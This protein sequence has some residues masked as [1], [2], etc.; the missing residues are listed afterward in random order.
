MAWRAHLDAVLVR[1]A[2]EAD[3]L[4]ETDANLAA[5]EGFGPFGDPAR[6][7]A[8]LALGFLD[9][10]APS[11]PAGTLDLAVIVVRDTLAAKSLACAD[12]PA[13]PAATVRW[14]FWNGSRWQALDLLKDETLAFTRSGHIHVKMP[15]KGITAKIRLES[16]LTMPQRHWIRARLD[17]S[18][19]ERAPKIRAIRINTVP[20]EQAETIRDE[21][22]GGSDGSRFQRFALGSR[23]VLARF[24]QAR[25]PAERRWLRA[26]DRGRGLLCV[27]SSR[28]SLRPRP[29]HRH[30]PHRRRS[31]RQHSGGLRPQP[32]RQRRR[33]RVQDRRRPPRKRR[34]RTR[35]ARSS[36]RIDGIDE[37]A[38]AN[39]L[40]ASGGRDEETLDEAR[41]R[42]PRTIRSRERAVTAEDYEYFAMQAG[43]VARAKALALFHPLFPDVQ[44][45]GA[46]TVIVVPDAD[47]PAPEPSEGLLRTVCACL[48]ARRTLTAELFVMKPQYQQVS[49]DVDLTVA[50]DADVT[51]VAERLEQS[52]LDY[53]H[54][55]RGGDNGL[56]WPFGGTIYYSKVYQRVFADR[57]VASIATLTITIDGEAQPACTDVP[58]AAHALVYL[59]RPHDLGALPRRGGI[60]TALEP[61]FERVP[62]IP[63]PPFDPTSLLIDDRSGW[64]VLSTAG[65]AGIVV[66][67][68]DGSLSLAVSESAS[69]HFTEASGSFGGLVP[70]S[71]IALTPDGSVLLLDPVSRRLRR[72]DPCCCRFVDLPCSSKKPGGG[73]RD[74][75]HPGGIAVC[76]DQLYIADTGRDG[77]LASGTSAGRNALRASIR[78]QNHRVSVFLLPGLELVGHVRP[79]RQ[80]YPQWQP[81]AVAC[82]RQHCVWVLDRLNGAIHRFTRSG[83]PVAVITGLDRPEHL[84]IDDGDRL[85]VVDRSL[86]T[87]V[88]RL[89]VFDRSGIEQEAP[90]SVELAAP[91]FRPL[92]FAVHAN[93]AISLDELCTAECP[94]DSTTFDSSGDPIGVPA[95]AGPPFAT[96]GVYLSAALD[97][98]T[99][100]CQWH[101]VVVHG[102]LPAGT[103]LRVETFCG[104][105]EYNAD[106]VG[107]LA[108]WTRTNITPLT[109]ADAGAALDC[110][111]LSPPGRYM[112]L[113]LTL[114]GN[115]TATPTVRMLENRVPAVVVAALPPGCLLG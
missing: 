35:S 19:Y 102:D 45:P 61:R 28:R 6:D 108:V 14:E 89:R 27:G 65:L 24:A 34:G 12:A 38:V 10:S 31:Q 1:R 109:L 80:R 46:V 26:V 94:P 97:S 66:S 59:H 70:P 69:R 84:A 42:A 110:L 29:Q 44:V 77:R 50:D 96:S 92:P 76:G 36:T 113:R 22:L 107:G 71:H 48:D 100:S 101:R 114:L 53:F 15:P 68:C 13:Y 67:L 21:V 106:M 82:D 8:E 32:R 78:R 95:P 104:D 56:G 41:A 87:D 91:S 98:R 52:L 105:E 112:W 99:R 30:D 4:P 72:F 75:R 18:Q 23:P 9:P 7:G 54:P 51:D 111:V 63:E 83:R 88:A 25:D 5:D 58:I 47:D 55:L 2:G 37:N 90:P 60:M 11:L 3:Y 33:S 16:D 39:L 85:F 81:V 43:N 49:I 115:G 93:G 17:R 79:P 86:K 64:Q 40:P 20:V 62:P 57:D 103:R 74:L 73:A